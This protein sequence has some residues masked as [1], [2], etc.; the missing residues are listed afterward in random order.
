MSEP[1]DDYP[2]AA[3]LLTE[4][5]NN[6][7]E[8]RARRVLVL[9]PQPFYED[10]GTPIAVHQLLQALSELQCSID[11]VTYPMGASPAIPGVEYHRVANPLRFREVPIGLSGRKVV[12]DLAMLAVARRLLRQRSY[13]VIHAV[14]EAA[15][16][17]VMLGRRHD[18]PV[19]YDMQS[20]LPEQMQKYPLFGNRFS[21][22]LVRASERWLI[23]NVQKVVSSAGLGDHVRAI[24]PEVPVSEWRFHAL[25]P[26][27]AES[28]SPGPAELRR[29]LGIPAGAPVVLYSGN[30]AP[31]QGIRLLLDAIPAVLE[32]CPGVVFVLVGLEGR[33]SREL[34]RGAEEWLQSGK[35]QLVGRQPR[36]RVGGYLAMANVLVSPRTDGANLPLKVFDYL[37]AGRPIVATDLAAHRGVLNGTRAVLVVPSPEGLARGILEVLTDPRR[38]EELRNAATAYADRHLGW[39][40]FVQFVEGLHGS[41]PVASGA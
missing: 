12:L 28:R 2:T 3:H 13:Y 11:V 16:L 18:V 37:H 5:R 34:F 24:A 6:S 38:A 19:I 25:D 41:M 23:R 22:R 15:F 32:K 14:E 8:R 35:L 17:G 40:Q 26:V 9:A 29:D 1:R 10:R 30:F 39:R 36:E 20:S 27:S 33:R 31:Y 21:K 4:S 7:R